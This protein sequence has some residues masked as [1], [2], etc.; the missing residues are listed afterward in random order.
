MN[1]NAAL[2]HPV[3]GL[4]V[5]YLLAFALPWLVWST[6]IAEQ[7]GLLG[8]HVPQSLAFWIGLPVAWL[9]AA[10]TSGG[11]AA[12]LDLF[13]RLLR[14]RVG[15][16]PYAMA[17][18]LAVL[19]PVAV[20]VVVLAAGG[21]MPS[22]GAAASGVPIA[23]LVEIALFWLTEEA[24]WRGFVLP[25]VELTL[26]PGQASLVVGVLWAVWHLPLFA[27]AGSF[28]SG[29]PFLGFALLTVATSVVLGWLSHRASGSVLVCALYHGVVDVVFATTGVLGAS[30]AAFWAVVVV[31]VVVAAALGLREGWWRSGVRAAVSQG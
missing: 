21:P 28:Q 18:A 30:P 24:M 9:V 26:R 11:R 5:G 13:S 10:A 29:L 15:W 17:L 16:R 12:V 8:W 4:I 2:A 3:R 6:L 27:I 14:W 20:W 7:R 25:R 31:H 19:L 1:E 22:A 23:L